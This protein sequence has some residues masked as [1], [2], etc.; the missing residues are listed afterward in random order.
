[1]N[2]QPISTI[3]LG[4][5]YTFG[6]AAKGADELLRQLM[7]NPKA[8]IVDVRL[9]P[10]SRWRPG[11]NVNALF[12]RYNATEQAHLAASQHTTRYVWLGATLGNKNYD[13]DLP[14]ELVNAQ[15]GLRQLTDIL[16][17][18]RDVVLL[19]ACSRYITCHRHV[20]VDLLRAQLPHLEVIIR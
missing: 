19:C 1:M 15:E 5:V 20:I 16:T 11:Y 4:K 9:S 8:L 3:A 6:Y 13:N 18:G 10:Y 17:R 2:Q 14:I 7:E 12:T